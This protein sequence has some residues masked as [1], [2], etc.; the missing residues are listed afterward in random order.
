MT[1]PRFVVRAVDIGYGNTKFVTG[2]PAST[3]SIDCDIF[4]S[5]SPRSIVDSDLGGADGFLMKRNTSKVIVGGM[6]YEVGPDS[7]KAQ[8]G[9]E[10][11]RVLKEDYCLSDNYRALLYGALLKMNEP[12]IHVLVLGLPMSTWKHYKDKLAASI[13]GSHKITREFECKIEK[14]I[15]AP[16]PLGGFYD[17]GLGIG[18]FKAMK[19]QINLIIDPGFSHL[20][21]F[22]RMAS[23]Q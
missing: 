23:R 1:K 16:Q 14:V 18:Q 4:P 6:E 10:S 8:F 2:R 5:L 15:V 22:M 7:S 3:N 12:H 21:G 13:T 20:T 17:H 11:G 9:N 19:E